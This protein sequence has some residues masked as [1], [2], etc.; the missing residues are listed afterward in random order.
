MGIDTIDLYWAHMDDRSTDQAETVDAFGGLLED[1][2]IRR[3]GASNWALWR[4]ER[5]RGIALASGG[6]QPSALQLRYSYLQPR[7]LARDH[8]HDHRFGWITDETLDYV[9]ANPD[10]G[11]WAYSPLMSGAYDRVDR[12]VPEGFEHPGTQRRLAVLDDV[13]GELG[14]SRSTAVI[15]WLTGGSPAIRPIVG[16]SAADQL[17]QAIAGARLTLGAEQRERLDEAW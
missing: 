10:V 2:T 17:E 8:L 5:A 16:V 13:A 11:L 7:P 6:A 12:A 1:G 4:V 9:Q 15:S 14:V 3:L